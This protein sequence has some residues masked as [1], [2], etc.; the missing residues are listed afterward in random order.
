MLWFSGHGLLH[1]SWP[2]KTPSNCIL[3]FLPVLTTPIKHPKYHRLCFH[4]PRQSTSAEFLH[5]A[6][7]N[8]RPDV[9]QPNLLSGLHRQRALWPPAR[10]GQVQSSFMVSLGVADR[11]EYHVKAHPET[12]PAN[13]HPNYSTV[14]GKK[15]TMIAS[16]G[17]HTLRK[18]Q[19]K[20]SAVFGHLGG[21]LVIPNAGERK[22]VFVSYFYAMLS[23][24]GFNLKVQY[25]YSH[26]YSVSHWIR[27][28]S[29]NKNENTLIC[30]PSFPSKPSNSGFGICEQYTK[31]L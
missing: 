5:A 27:C 8:C 3:L 2:V 12:L 14:E 26:L 25:S 6:R 31:Y 10:Q 4:L 11:A 24:N 23:M 22:Y 7:Y 29:P 20:T 30:S 1:W 21:R 15:T 19:F 9:Q 28:S 18:T 13:L 16:N 17:I